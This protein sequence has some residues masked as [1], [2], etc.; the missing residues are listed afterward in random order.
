MKLFLCNLKFMTG[1]FKFNFNLMFFSLQSLFHASH[2]K[3]MLALLVL[4]FLLKT[5]DLFF[6]E[7]N[8]PFTLPFGIRLRL[9]QPCTFRDKFLVFGF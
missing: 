1:L 5:L 7:L 3:F 4:D 2:L 9:F 8:L 6:H